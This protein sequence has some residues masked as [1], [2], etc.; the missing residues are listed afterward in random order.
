MR[1]ADPALYADVA[2]ARADGGGG[3][4]GEVVLE[5]ES[6]R[7]VL[8][9]PVDPA[10]VHAMAAVRQDLRSRGQPWR[11]L[12]GRYGG[13]VVA[14]G[15]VRGGV[16]PAARGASRTKAVALVSERNPGSGATNAAAVGWLS[17]GAA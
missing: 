14:R 5:L 13:W 2:A 4:G 17:S 6:G 3:A 16:R 8:A 11:E 10:V 9:T 15:V 12:D 7:L 1:A